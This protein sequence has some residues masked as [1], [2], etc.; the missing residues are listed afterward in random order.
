MPF[1]HPSS[2]Q[3]SNTFIQPY[4]IVNEHLM[5]SNDSSLLNFQAGESTLSKYRCMIYRFY[6]RW[7]GEN[8]STTE[9]GTVLADGQSQIASV[10][11]YGVEIPGKYK[12]FLE[13]YFIQSTLV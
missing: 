7:K 10:N 6:F 5:N 2:V 13:L 3:E 4:S 1:L 9:V 12:I 11:V 8:V